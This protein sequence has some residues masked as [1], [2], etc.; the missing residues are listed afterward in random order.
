MATKHYCDGCGK[1]KEAKALQLVT[2]SFGKTQ[3]NPKTFDLC[4][5]CL[6]T[7]ESD[8]YPTRWVR[9]AKEPPK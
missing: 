7:F 9:L 5:W 2:V 6:R 1:E 4:D 3:N 8:H